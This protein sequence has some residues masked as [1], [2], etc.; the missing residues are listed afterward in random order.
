[1]QGVLLGARFNYSNTQKKGCKFPWP[2][3]GLYSYTIIMPIV[4]VSA[5]MGDQ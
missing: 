4:Y 5:I 2:Y 3:N 1:M